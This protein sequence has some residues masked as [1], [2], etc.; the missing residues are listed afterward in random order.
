MPS[1]AS[2]PL[3][4]LAALVVQAVSK[5]AEQDKILDQFTS[6]VSR[7][8]FKKH[9][10][11]RDHPAMQNLLQQAFDA[12]QK[13]PKPSSRLAPG[14]VMGDKI[15]SPIVPW[16][17]DHVK[18]LHDEEPTGMFRMKTVM[19]TKTE[20][21]IVNGL[22]CWFPEGQEITF[23]APWV[24]TY[25][26]SIR[27]GREFGRHMNWL[28]KQGPWGEHVPPE[29]QPDPDPD[30]LTDEGLHMRAEG[31]GMFRPGMGWDPKVD[32]KRWIAGGGPAPDVEPVEPAPA[33][34]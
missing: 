23:Y 1:D 27:S 24:D 7:I 29:M 12:E 26:Q 10:E 3:K 6:L 19:C 11:L 16:T 25:M 13:A 28:F 30:W 9:P 2:D 21:V 17:W 31:Q 20:Q 22:S 14:T 32:G 15:N 4:E 18:F 8:D 33:A 34:Q 5:D